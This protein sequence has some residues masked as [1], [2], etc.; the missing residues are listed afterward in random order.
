MSST[1][2]SNREAVSFDADWRFQRGDL[3]F[4]SHRF[5]IT[6]WQWKLVGKTRPSDSPASLKAVASSRSGWR[7]G[8]TRQDSFKSPGGFAWFKTL[9]PDL[10]SP[11]RLAHFTLVSEDCLVYLNGKKLQANE[12]WINP[13]DVSLDSAW[14]TGGPNLLLVLVENPFGGPYIGESEVE[15]YSPSQ[16]PTLPGFDDSK[17]RSLHLPHDF[18][19]EGTFDKKGVDYNGYLPTGIGWYRKAFEVP[20]SMEAATFGW[21]STGLPQQPRLAQRKTS[22]PP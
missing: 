1:H 3:P 21:I 2:R 9:L 15:C 17:W 22:G 20:A 14:K 12:R 7:K 10:P 13:F 19:V 6:T 4:S 18:V 8:G 16:G 5:P 11:G